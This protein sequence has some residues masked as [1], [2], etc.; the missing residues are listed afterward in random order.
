MLLPP[1]LLFYDPVHPRALDPPDRSPRCRCR[2]TWDLHGD[3][4]GVVS[5]HAREGGRGGSAAHSQAKTERMYCNYN[6]AIGVCKAHRYAKRKAK[7]GGTRRGGSNGSTISQYRVGF[8]LRYVGRIVSTRGGYSRY[9]R[10]ILSLILQAD[11]TLKCRKS[12]QMPT[13]RAFAPCEGARGTLGRAR[14][15]LRVRS[16]GRHGLRHV[17]I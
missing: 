13:A 17:E 3:L 1:Q 7:D 11:I 9:I 5:G 15:K 2:W 6:T 12:P 10:D 14:G 8:K 4:L 16:N